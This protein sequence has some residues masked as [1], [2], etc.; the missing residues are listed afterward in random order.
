MS[1][2]SD[3]KDRKGDHGEEKDMFH[4]DHWPIGFDKNGEPNIV[5]YFPGGIEEFRSS[6]P[7]QRRRSKY[8]YWRRGFEPEN[9]TL[10]IVAEL[11]PVSGEYVYK[12][13]PGA[14]VREEPLLN[15]LVTQL[16]VQPELKDEGLGELRKQG[17]V[18][19][20]ATYEPVNG[21]TKKQRER[22]AMERAYNELCGDATYEP[23]KALTERERNKVIKRDY[24]ELCGDLKRL[25]G[26]CW[27]KVPLVLIKANVCR[28]L[29]KRLKGDG[30]NVLNEGRLVY[31][32]SHGHQPHFDR[33][34]R[35]I[36]P[37]TL[38]GKG[39]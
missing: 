33:Q 24:D 25:L 30:F 32:P 7:V 12:P 1:T 11:P 17:W 28:L 14:K 37:Q 22:E 35:E 20:D 13:K 15:A 36:V 16:G 3:P 8:L 4:D 2:T 27:R 5:G 26:T 31:F 19:V 23:V 18:L 38:R 39:L 9:V 6:T 21:P 34:F 10:V 29:D